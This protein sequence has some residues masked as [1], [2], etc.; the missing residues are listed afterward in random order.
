M[1]DWSAL[2][3][4]IAGDVIPAGSPGYDAARRPAIARFDDVRPRAVVRCAT[5]SDVA[6]TIALAGRAGLP[7]AIRSGGHCFAGRSSTDGGV[8]IDVG[9]MGSVSVSGGVATV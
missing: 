7:M 1:T 3:R 9:P 2:Q 4:A 8:V 6:A 5:P